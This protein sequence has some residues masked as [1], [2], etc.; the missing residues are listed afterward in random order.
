MDGQQNGRGG[1]RVKWVKVV[2]CMVTNGSQIFGGENAV[3]YTYV[4]L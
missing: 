3:V 2:N 4:K 1:G